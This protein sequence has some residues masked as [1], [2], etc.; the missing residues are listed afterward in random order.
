MPYLEVNQ[1]NKDELEEVVEIQ[2]PDLINKSIKEAEKIAKEQN[3]EL[4]IEN[5]NEGEEIDKQNTIIT[6]QIPRP[7]ITIKTGS[8][9]YVKY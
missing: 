7:G 4:V 9:V 2:T 6:D 5:L 1:G 8:K 3:I